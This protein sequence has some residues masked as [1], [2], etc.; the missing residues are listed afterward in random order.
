MF[1]E[2]S[3]NVRYLFSNVFSFVR[4]I[5]LVNDDISAIFGGGGVRGEGVGMRLPQYTTVGNQIT[6]KRISYP[7]GF[8]LILQTVCTVTN[9]LRFNRITIISRRYV[10]LIYI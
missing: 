3:S 1:S 6:E 10:C 5:T 8:T 9:K 4:N 2:V 7:L